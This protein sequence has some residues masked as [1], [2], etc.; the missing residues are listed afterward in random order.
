MK[1]R[2][3]EALTRS[4]VYSSEFISWRRTVPGLLEQ[5]SLGKQA[6]HYETVLIKPNLVE[7]LA[8]PITTPVD[9]VEQIVLYLLDYVSADRIVIGEGCGATNHDTHYAFKKLGYTTL[10]QQH[11]IRLIDLN[12]AKLRHRKDPRLSRWPEMYLPEILDNAFLLS[13][14]QLK[15]HSLSGVTLT[16]KNMMGCA[17]PAHYQRGGAWN[18]SAFHT[19]IHEAIFELNRY[20]TPDYTLL[21][22]SI[23]MAKAHLWG[24]QCSPH[25]QTIA[26]SFDPVAIDSYGT[27]LLGRDWR[28][29]GHIVMADGILGNAGL[30]SLMTI[31]KE[32]TGMQQQV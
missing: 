1:N 9:L 24:P 23:G 16:M 28:K 5:S 25:V 32:I 11:N 20:R 22:A 14:P 21:D 27:Q 13:V 8:P 31:T 12:T 18:K 29:I 17:P 2:N 19:K 3:H 4:K 15:A 7:I 6:A 30:Y 10:A 26:A